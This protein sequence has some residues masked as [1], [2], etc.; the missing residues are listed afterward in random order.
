MRSLLLPIAAFVVAWW[1]TGRFRRYAIAR[2]LLDVPNA[3]SSHTVPTPR[4][5]GVAIV[6]TTLAAIPALV[7]IDAL[8]WYAASGL[9]GG[10]A[11]V[12]TVGFI[13]DKYG[14]TARWRL[15]GHF[16]AAAWIVVWIL[17]FAPV[18]F[19]RYQSSLIWLTSG[20][21]TLYLVWLL[22]LTNFMD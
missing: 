5:G 17:G 4:G 19:D 1:L 14:V 9:F 11:L 20:F 3:R 16:V 15:V 6:L 18:Q 22:N 2:S 12:A 10:G 7:M 8:D 21:I 13:D